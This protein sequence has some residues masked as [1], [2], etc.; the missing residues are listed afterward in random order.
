MDAIAV[1]LDTRLHQWKPEVS[2]EVRKAVVLHFENLDG[3]SF[4]IT[5]KK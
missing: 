4:D 1:K 3:T 2:V 5:E